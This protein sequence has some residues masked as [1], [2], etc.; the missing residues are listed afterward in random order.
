M[1]W[2]VLHS[3]ISCF[4]GFLADAELLLFDDPL[5]AVVWA[6]PSL[7]FGWLRVLLAHPD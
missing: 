1:H 6:R 7:Q 4:L 2:D 5:S 3:L